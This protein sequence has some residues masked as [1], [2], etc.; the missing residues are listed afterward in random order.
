MVMD[1]DYKAAAPGRDLTQS[2][3]SRSS[4][5]LGLSSLGSSLSK[6]KVKVEGVAARMK[7]IAISAEPTKK[8]ANP[9]DLNI[10]RIEKSER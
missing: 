6:A 7:R 2:S 1:D 4:G 3:E 9:K 10:E 5:G 8:V